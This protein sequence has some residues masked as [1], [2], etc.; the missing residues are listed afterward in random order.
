MEKSDNWFAI[1]KVCE[2]HLEEKE[3]L[4]KTAC[5]FTF[6]T[7]L[8]LEFSVYASA[9]QPPVSPGVLFELTDKNFKL[10]VDYLNE[11]PRIFQVCE[12]F[13]I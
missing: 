12:N 10:S 2:K 11:L 13:T 8:R 7:I 5:I 1:A 4:S 3:I 6:N 9:K